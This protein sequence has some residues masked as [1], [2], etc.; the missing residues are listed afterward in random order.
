MDEGFK[1]ERNWEWV[2]PYGFSYM[3]TLWGKPIYFQHF[4]DWNEDSLSEHQKA[5]EKIRVDFALKLSGLFNPG[6]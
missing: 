5:I 2:H 4:Q 6:W 1:V 3:V